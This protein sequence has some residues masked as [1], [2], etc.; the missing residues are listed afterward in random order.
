MSDHKHNTPTFPRISKW[1]P[2]I[3]EKASTSNINHKHAAMILLNGSPMAY[4][5]NDMRGV[6]PYHA[7]S[8]VIRS[9]LISCGML[10]WVKT[11]RILWGTR[12]RKQA[13]G[14]Y[15]HPSRHVSH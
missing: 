3:I 4:G 5:I 7:E 10:G 15:V 14:P 13:K 6:T 12:Q 11:Q 1:I 2:N 9:Y 8:S